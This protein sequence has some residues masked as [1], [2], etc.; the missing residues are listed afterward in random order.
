MTS[1]YARQTEGGTGERTHQVKGRLEVLQ[2]NLR[3]EHACI[4]RGE[5]RKGCRWVGMAGRR[6]AG[7]L[8]SARAACGPLKGIVDPTQACLPALVRF[9]FLGHAS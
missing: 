2:G 5:G 3:H 1:A 9:L 6:G 7:V 8:G 4:E